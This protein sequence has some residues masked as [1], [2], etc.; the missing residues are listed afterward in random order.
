M[1]TIPPRQPLQAMCRPKTIR[2]VKAEARK[3]QLSVSAWIDKIL[4]EELTR[5]GRKP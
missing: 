4:L 3:D 1:K 5:R 2:A